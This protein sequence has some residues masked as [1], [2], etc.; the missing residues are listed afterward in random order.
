MT[1]PI[2]RGQIL[3]IDDDR[4]PRESLRFLL[5]TLHT[6]RAT[7]SVREGLAALDEQ[8]FEVILLDLR[9]PEMDG[10]T[11]LRAIRERD[12]LVSVVILTGYASW[13]TAADAVRLG[14]NE[15][16][17]KPYDVHK[18]RDTVERHLQATR[19]RRQRV[20][21]VDTLTQLHNELRTQLVNQSGL[22]TLGQNANEMLHDLRNPLSV[23]CGYTQLLLREL[24]DPA[25]RQNLPPE[26]VAQVLERTHQELQHCKDLADLWRAVGREPITENGAIQLPALAAE[27]LATLGPHIA[28]RSISVTIAVQGPE[29]A[30]QAWGSRSQFQRVLSTLLQN[31][32]DMVP[33]GAGK[34]ELL[35]SCTATEVWSTFADNGPGLSSHDLAHVFDPTHQPSSTAMSRASTGSSDGTATVARGN[36]LGLYLVQKIVDTYSGRIQIESIEGEGTLIRVRL[37]RHIPRP[38]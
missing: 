7:S 21:S 11:G 9:M 33:S 25:L 18:V 37:P 20:A 30:I 16:L 29:E 14:A 6:V 4:G 12:E 19:T 13:E 15:Y 35:L 8:P 24:G 3:I 10:I 36:G 38:E 22:V 27:C 2:P 5:G 34:V 28:Q 17:T 23:A 31:A 1:A 32:I 26:H